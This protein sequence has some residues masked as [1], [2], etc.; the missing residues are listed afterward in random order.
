VT[1]LTRDGSDTGSATIPQRA[2]EPRSLRESLT[3]QYGTAVGEAMYE[4]ELAARRKKA[5]RFQALQVELS[6][7]NVQIDVALQAQS[8]NLLPYQERMDA[9]YSN[10]LRCSDEYKAARDRGESLLVTGLRNKAAELIKAINTPIFA[11]RGQ[12]WTN[13]PDSQLQPIPDSWQEPR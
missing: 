10:Y 7:L 2:P 8:K 12:N 13:V 9:A 3:A 6:A 11:D 1:D 5:E 4:I